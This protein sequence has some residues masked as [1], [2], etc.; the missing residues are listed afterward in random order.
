M[1]GAAHCVGSLSGYNIRARLCQ[2]LR[3]GRIAVQPLIKRILFLD[4]NGATHGEMRNATKLFAHDVIAA[5]P[6][7]LE[8]GVRGHAGNQVHLHAKLG[9]GEI[10]QHVL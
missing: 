5:C 2:H 4:Y 7:W 6:C 9:H 1:T 10:V 8:P 3:K